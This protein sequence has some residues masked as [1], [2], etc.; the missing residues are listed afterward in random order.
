M[1]L[2]P[3]QIYQSMMLGI[4]VRIRAIDHCLKKNNGTLSTFDTEFC[5]LNSR[6]II[7][8]I[9]FSSIL[10]D[11]KRYEDFRSLE[12]E[13]G[14]KDHGNYVKDWKAPMILKKMRDISPHFMPRPLGQRKT[15][16]DTHHYDSGFQATHAELIDMWEKCGSFLHVSKPF[17][18]G[19]ESHIDKTEEKYSAGSAAI[20]S[21][22]Q[23]FKDLL[24]DH[25]AIGL[26]YEPEDGGLNSVEAANP[27]TA[28]LVHFGDD[29][30][31]V[32]SVKVAIG[33][34]RKSGQ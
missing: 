5:F 18:E 15:N 4:K 30:S 2:E 16:D 12:R 32:I 11:K 13:T 19:Y 34:S 21:Y 33:E 7:E 6:M 8:Q 25:A 10:C 1:T 26:E 20:E 31:D 29:S 24:W 23:Y 3:Y 27:I 14:S 28:W 22:S 17:G 9:C